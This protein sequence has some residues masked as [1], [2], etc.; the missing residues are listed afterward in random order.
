LKRKTV[1][2]IKNASGGVRSRHKA[3]EKR[4]DGKYER[5]RL[6]GREVV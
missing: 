1:I 2:S 3:G 6:S 4:D 5:V